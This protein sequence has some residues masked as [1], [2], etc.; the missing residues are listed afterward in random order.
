MSLLRRDRALL[1]A[2]R[3]GEAPA[4]ERVYREYVDLVTDVVRRGT[5]FS[6][7]GR[8]G[9]VTGVDLYDLVQESF[10]RA[11]SLKARLAYD[12]V[13]D[14]RPYLLTIVRNLLADWARKRGREVPSEAELEP[15]APEEPW[16]DP[17]TMAAVEAYVRDLEP[18]LDRLYEVRFVR[19]VS[20]AEAASEMGIGR[21][22]V[23]TLEKR[24]REGLVARLAN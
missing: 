16:A 11:F 20:Q 24:L 9:G 22:S 6:G 8:V 17:A 7:G 14:Y 5:N 1:E 12:G 10:A 19:G 21:Q 4:L 2:F 23:R 15:P 13:R 3:A 18:P